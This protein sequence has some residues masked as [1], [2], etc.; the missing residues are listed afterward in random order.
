MPGAG[1]DWFVSGAL[2]CYFWL[3]KVYI[4]VEG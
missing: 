1:V 4:D 3:D 2:Y